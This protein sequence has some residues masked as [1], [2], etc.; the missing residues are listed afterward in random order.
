[1]IIV[2]LCRFIQCSKCTMLGDVD[3]RKGCSK[4]SLLKTETNNKQHYVVYG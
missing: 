3:G 1:M 4:N 2:Y